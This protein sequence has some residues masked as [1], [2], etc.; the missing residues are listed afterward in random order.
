MPNLTGMVGS[1]PR[2]AIAFHII[3]NSGASM[4]MKIA[5]KNWV[6]PAEIENRPK[7]LMSVLRSANSVSDDPAC[8]NSDQNTVLKV[9]STIAA[10]II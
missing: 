6:C 8:S 9:I 5:L 7:T 1:I 3:E 2:L 10:T 4:T